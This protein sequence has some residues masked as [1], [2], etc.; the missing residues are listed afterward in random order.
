MILTCLITELGDWCEF[1][2]AF[3]ELTEYF[4]QEFSQ[5][6]DIC[7]ANIAQWCKSYCNVENLN[8]NA[9]S[10]KDLF[11]SLKSSSSYNFLNTG[12]MKHLANKSGIESLQ[13]CVNRYEEKISGL[14]LQDIS[15]K[16]NVIGEHLSEEDVELISSLLQDEVTLRQLQHICIPRWLDDETLTL[17]C[18]T[19]LPEFYRLFTVGV[20]LLYHILHRKEL[21][22]HNL[23]TLVAT[24]CV[25]FKI[26]TCTR[27]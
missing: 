19:R 12:L 1:E 25:I 13:E 10:A 16:V 20:A 22:T 18:G 7:I 2:K 21:Y 11:A 9:S 15:R 14:T 17:D 27:F 4:V 26:Q 6:S 23:A 24:V 5:S 8:Q 3:E